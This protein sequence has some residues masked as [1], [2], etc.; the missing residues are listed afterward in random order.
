M[1]TATIYALCEVNLSDRSLLLAGHQAG[2]LVLL[3]LA[4]KCHTPSDMPSSTP[5][6]GKA[7][8]ENEQVEQVW[9][10]KEE[11]ATCPK[12]QQVS[13]CIGYIAPNKVM[14][15]EDVSEA[16]F[17]GTGRVFGQDF[18]SQITSMVKTSSNP[19]RSPLPLVE[20]VKATVQ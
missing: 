1:W 19:P 4:A 16:L 10:V 7:W 11:I 13:E 14:S 12:V 6:Q 3:F 20:V 5:N 18:D 17:A 2:N 8:R 15:S 9:R